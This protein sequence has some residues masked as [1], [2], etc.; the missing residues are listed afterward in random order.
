VQC[1]LAT[2][3]GLLREENQDI[4]RAERFADNVLAVVCDG[5]GGERSGLLASKRT[6]EVFFDE[7]CKGYKDNFE[8]EDI[9][10]LM[11]SSVSAANLVIYSLSRM[12]Y[13]SFGMGT[14]CIAAFCTES[15][16]SLINVGDSRAYYYDNGELFLLTKDH[17]AANMLYEK[18]RISQS[19]LKTHPQRHMLTKAVGA[20]KTIEA[21]YFTM[22]RTRDSKLLLCSDGLSGYCEDIEICKILSEDDDNQK[23]LKKLMHL[24]LDKGG[25]DNI[26]IALINEF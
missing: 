4:V 17:T 8:E 3:I 20:E 7:F 11:I 16:I 5:M 25:R 24:A 15:R 18:G 6:M 13:R 26:S 9:K 2:D 23:T 1:V 12:N 14:T 21:D 19:E 10:K 22:T